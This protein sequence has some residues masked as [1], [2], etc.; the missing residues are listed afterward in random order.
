MARLCALMLTLVAGGGVGWAC[1][2]PG[3]GGR[4]TSAKIMLFATIGPTEPA[5]R[6][7]S[8]CSAPYRGRVLLCSE[9]GQTSAIVTRS[10]GRGLASLRPGIYEIPEQVG[11]PFPR[12]A[13][14]TANGRPVAL[15]KRG[16]YSIRLVPGRDHLR[17]VFDTGIR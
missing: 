5:C 13:S 14:V 8:P 1:S 15:D 4:S 2:P 12:F 7:G 3:E 10:Q 6:V 11:M 16:G 17:L 9:D